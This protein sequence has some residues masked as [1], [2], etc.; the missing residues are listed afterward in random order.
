MR[1][2][3]RV[4]LPCTKSDEEPGGRGHVCALSPARRGNPIH[5]RPICM[6]PPDGH[7]DTVAGAKTRQGYAK[8]LALVQALCALPPRLLQRMAVSTLSRTRG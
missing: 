7:A 5:P 6:A 1:P 3:Q 2:M 4:I 8:A